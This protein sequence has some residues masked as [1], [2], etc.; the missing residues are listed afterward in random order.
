MAAGGLTLITGVQIMSNPSPVMNLSGRQILF[1][2]G[3]GRHT[4]HFRR[5][6]EQANGSF[7]YHDGGMEDNLSRL[8]GLFRRAD[9]VL[10]PVDCIS[11]AAQSKV[12][13]LCRESG[14]PFYPIQ[15]T[16]MGAFTRAL[17]TLSTQQKPV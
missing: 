16:G 11:H 12:K 9:V 6:V 5:L 3:R 17:E 2:G 15:R 1:V 10:F 4:A 8:S 13:Q 14:V 7:A